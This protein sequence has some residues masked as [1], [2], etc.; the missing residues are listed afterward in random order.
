MNI[1]IIE[2]SINKREEIESVINDELT[3]NNNRAVFSYAD[4]LVLA[5]RQ[6]QTEVFD[7]II[8]DMFMPLNT[9]LNEEVDCSEELIA[10]FSVSKNYQTESIALT[11]FEI[12]EIDNFQSFNSAGITV[13]HFSD[14]KNWISAL[15]Q[16]ITRASQKIKC[17]FLI[18]CA[19]SKE[20]NAFSEADCKLGKQKN[21]FGM[22]CLEISIGDK[23]GFIIKPHN[24]GLVNMA[25][26]SAKA[27]ELFQPK[28][29]SM[30]GI[31]AGVKG[32]S[33]YL[34]IVVGKACWEYQTGKWKDGT[35]KQEPYQSTLSRGLEVDLE[36]SSE[37]QDI[38]NRIRNNIYKDEVST[39][40]IILAPISSGSA[41]IADEKMMESI[42]FQ[43][44]KM[45]A[46]EMEM[47]ALYEAAAQSLCQPLYFGAKSVVDLGDTNKSDT[48]HDPACKL[49]ARYV[50]LMIKRQFDKIL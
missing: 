28:I 27:I 31:C 47:Y 39:M 14:N 46:L 25:I 26:T 41:V 13:V 6:L 38:R 23:N 1:L 50:A 44:R 43:H 20:R 45:A 15:R 34:D 16:K 33:N 2:D 4:N 42:G 32:E 3:N 29:V 11:Q 37:D 18:F 48:F 22:N 19:L 36:Q 17:D 49:S 7:L 8:F 12:N 10:E 21:I 5:R 40:R 9:N 30:S 24:M 35:F